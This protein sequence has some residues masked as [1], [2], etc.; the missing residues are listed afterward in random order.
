MQKQISKL[1][2]IIGDSFSV[3][4]VLYTITKEISIGRTNADIYLCSDQDGHRYIAKY[5]CNRVPVS[6]IGYSVYNHYGRGR[7]GSAHVFQE[8]K[9]KSQKYSFIIRQYHRIRY[10]GSWLILMDYIEGETL[11]VFIRCNYQNNLQGVKSAVENLAMTLAE[12]HN[13]GFAHGD[14]HLQNCLYTSENKV[15]LIDYGQI[16]HYSFAHCWKY[17][18][19]VNDNLIRIKEDFENDSNKLGNGF[20]DNLTELQEELCLDNILVDFFNDVYRKH[21]TLDIFPPSFFK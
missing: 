16:H 8:V 20:R 13:N 19:I 21:T 17:G 14:P 10:K 7:D 18:C 11:D 12:W 5:Y 1:Q 15:F 3:G 9:D 2:S 4:D 6:V